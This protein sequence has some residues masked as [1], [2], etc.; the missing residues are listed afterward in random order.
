MQVTV[1]CP[2]C[3]HRFTATVDNPEQLEDRPTAVPVECTRCGEI[4]KIQISGFPT[5][6]SDP[7]L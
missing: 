6:D 4:I 2:R 3:K 5:K 1:N 7:P